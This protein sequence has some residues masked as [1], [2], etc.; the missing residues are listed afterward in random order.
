MTRLDLALLVLA[1]VVGGLVLTNRYGGSRP[2]LMSQKRAPGLSHRTGGQLAREGTSRP[3]FAFQAD[4][5]VMMSTRDVALFKKY[6]S[7]ADAFLEWGSG[8]STLLACNTTRS[9][10]VHSIDNDFAWCQQFLQRDDV[11]DAI[12]RGILVYTCG[13]CGDSTGFGNL[14]QASDIPRCRHTYIEYPRHFN[15]QF[16]LILVDGRFREACALYALSL[17]TESGRL[18]I[19]DFMGR[20]RQYGSVERFYTMLERGDELA[21]FSAKTRQVPWAEFRAKATILD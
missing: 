19:H 1:V 21:V 11:R 5:F 20:R 3:R 18:M 16:D 17:L 8:G 7:A 10:P 13:A 14:K 6:S 9:T 12:D 4:S 2:L 15:K